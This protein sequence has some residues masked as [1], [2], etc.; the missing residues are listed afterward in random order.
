[1]PYIGTSL[2]TN[3]AS[4]LRD[5]FTG[6]GSNTNFTYQETHITKMI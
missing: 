2:S 4:T 5:E 3:F 1:M 6:D